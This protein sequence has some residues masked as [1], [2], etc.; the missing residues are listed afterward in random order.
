M[1]FTKWVALFDSH[2][3]QIDPH[4]ERAAFE[5]IDHFKP[6]H[7]IAGGDHFD[8]RWLRGKASE[9]EKRERTQEDF[10]AGISF[11]KRFKPDVFLT[12]NHEH[13]L[14]RAARGD[15]GKLADFASHLVLDI[16]DALGGDCIL[17]PFGKRHGVHK[18]GDRSFVHGYHSGLY[19][20]RQAAMIYGKMC[21]GHIHA[22]DQCSIPR[23]DYCDGHSSGALCKIDLDYNESQPNTLR[24]NNGFV[25]GLK[26]Q[27]GTTVVWH[28]DKINGAFIFPSEFK[29]VRCA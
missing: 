11:I 21:M 3:D 17:I 7:R 6:H 8:L 20:V 9:G 25:Y 2:G 1:K 23:L 26:F 13:R 27:N 15:D 19:A 24:Q 5:F 28:A 29:E 16:K 14:W 12:G 22:S 4:A 10:D 18:H